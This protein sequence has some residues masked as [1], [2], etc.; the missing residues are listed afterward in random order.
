MNSYKIV[1]LESYGL[2]IGANNATPEITNM[3]QPRSESEKKDPDDDR[4]SMHRIPILRQV[5]VQELKPLRR[6]SP[7]P[8]DLLPDVGLLHS[9][10][11]LLRNIPAPMTELPQHLPRGHHEPRQLLLQAL[12]GHSPRP[13]LVHAV[14]SL[15]ENPPAQIPRV[16][17]LLVGRRDAGAVPDPGVLHQA[18]QFIL[19][20]HPTA[21]A[22]R[23][24]HRR[25]PQI[26]LTRGD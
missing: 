10:Q 15:L 16:P 21:A 2:A 19:P 25:C 24:R 13:L 8:L 12:L 22:A 11:A 17:L 5:L 23:R 6:H 20:R 18:G 7:M 4:P 14:I 3:R 9:L 1:R 26:F